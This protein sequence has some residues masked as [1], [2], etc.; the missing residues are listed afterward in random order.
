[1]PLT[2]RTKAAGLLAKAKVLLWKELPRLGP[3]QR[4]WD[5]LRSAAIKNGNDGAANLAFDAY[6]AAQDYAHWVNR[7]ATLIKRVSILTGSDDEIAEFITKLGRAGKEANKAFGNYVTAKERFCDRYSDETWAA[8]ALKWIVSDQPNF[9]AAYK[10]FKA[11]A[12]VA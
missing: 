4:R 11:L 9:Q 8:K 7:M 1:M 12:K 5:D 2:D 10:L 3:R 6:S